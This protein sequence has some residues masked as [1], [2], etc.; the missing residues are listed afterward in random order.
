MSLA[1]MHC[2]IHI[3]NF[4]LNSRQLITA[5][6]TISRVTREKFVLLYIVTQQRV[7]RFGE[8]SV[9][10]CKH[11]SRKFIEVILEIIL[12]LYCRQQLHSSFEFA[13]LFSTSAI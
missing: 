11:F 7:D 9:G 8:K 4:F 6:I 5:Q 3:G 10:L 12:L 1:K 13:N 2:K